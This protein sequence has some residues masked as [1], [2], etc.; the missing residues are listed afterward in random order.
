MP[1]APP[2][3]PRPRNGNGAN[4]AR[5]IFLLALAAGLF[6]H[7]LAL[8]LFRLPT[9]PPPPA[10]PLPPYVRTMDDYPGELQELAMLKDPEPVYLPTKHNFAQGASTPPFTHSRDP[11]G[12]FPLDLTLDKQDFPAK[13]LPSVPTGPV[14]SLRVER[15][16]FLGTFGQEAAPALKLPARG[17]HLVVVRLG[18]DAPGGKMVEEDWPANLA[19]PA[20]EAR[21]SP[22]HFLLLFNDTGPAGPPYLE[23]PSPL[24]AADTV[25]AVDNFLRD[26]LDQRFRRR[27]LPP[28]SYE[29]IIGP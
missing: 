24:E 6:V 10:Q 4:G 13:S 17:A 29:A 23:P 19:P 16:D 8:V 20:G 2:P 21:W 9:Q 3:T 7:G 14:E 1:S 18:A 11:Y 12:E 28:G 25:E 22:A 27:P 15:G 26:Q 5:P